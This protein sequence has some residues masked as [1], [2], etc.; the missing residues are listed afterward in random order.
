MSPPMLHLGFAKLPPRLENLS[1]P[2]HG[3][4]SHFRHTWMRLCAKKGMVVPLKQTSMRR[5]GS[6]RSRAS[7]AWPSAVVSSAAFTCACRS[8]SPVQAP[9]HKGERDVQIKASTPTS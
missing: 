2:R 8:A 1:R 4:L 6:S 9:Q 7:I 3:V 5:Q